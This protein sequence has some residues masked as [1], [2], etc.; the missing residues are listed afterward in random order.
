MDDTIAAIAT[1]IGPGAIGIVRISGP[2]ALEIIQRI[3]RP[4]NPRI[5][6]QPYRLT[7]GH[8]IE[9]ARGTP[10]DEVLVSFMKA[11]RS[12]TRED[13]V[14]INTHS[15]I[16][17]LSSVL[18]LVIGEGARLARPGEF[19]YRAYINGRIDLIQ[20][21]AV[22][23]LISS[24]SHKAMEMATRAIKGELSERIWTIREGIIGVLANVE[25]LIDFADEEDVE[26]E[27]PRLAQELTNIADSVQ[28][29][30]LAHSERRVWFEGINVLI[31]GKVN[32]GKSSLLNRLVGEP[33]AIVTS[34]P[35]TT[36][37]LIEVPLLLEGISVKFIDSAGL[38]T[39]KDEA[40]RQGMERAKEKAK[41]ADIVLLVVDQSQGLD[42]MDFGLISEFQGK[43][44]LVLNKSDLD[45]K[46][47]WEDLKRLGSVPHVRTSALEN[48]GIDELK[49]LIKAQVLR[50]LPMGTEVVSPN[51]R[52]AE[53]LKR[54]QNYLWSAMEVLKQEGPNEI[55]ALELKEALNVLGDITGEVLHEDI[56][57]KIFSSFCIGK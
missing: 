23:D 49:G 25:A 18:D 3:F 15:G 44:I 20:A 17:I 5:G 4:K 16:G 40:E 52:Q 51:Q 32:V 45:S 33:R 9:P 47:T 53:V 11:P 1:P 26:V 57:E 21:E 46:V 55:L 10:I 8:I 50:E 48:W 2:R 13:V 43:I 31:L 39:P 29:L 38:G 24:T 36:R 35:G 27:L 37:D 28:R 19:T 22:L 14:E 6:I 42:E 30:L 34:I 54:V 56:L 41:D 12:Y 7:L